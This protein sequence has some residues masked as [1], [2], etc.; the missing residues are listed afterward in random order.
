[1]DAQLKERVLSCNCL[2]MKDLNSSV[3]TLTKKTEVLLKAYDGRQSRIAVLEGEKQ[4][5]QSKVKGLMDEI[6]QLQEEN[7]VLRMAS[8]L[9]GDTENVGETKRK[10]S[11][12]VREI[13][14]CIAMMND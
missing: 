13:D 1:M 12:M 4:K 3:E 8:A 6:G 10:I 9:K 11:Q 7:K 2:F 14:R 5:L